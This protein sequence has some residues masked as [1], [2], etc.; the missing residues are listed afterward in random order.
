MNSRIFQSVNP[1]FDV[2]ES[3]I[4]ETPLGSFL[5]LADH[6][7]LYLLDFTDNP[8]LGQKKQKAITSTSSSVLVQSLSSSCS[9]SRFSLSPLQSI[10]LELQNYFA[11]ALETFTT[12]F[13][14]TGTPFQ[15]ETWKALLQIPFAK[16]WT[17]QEQA[18]ILGRPH[19]YRAVAN[20]NGANALVIL[21]PCHRVIQKKGN[22]GGYNGGPHRKQWLIHHEKNATN[23]TLF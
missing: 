11:G 19:A 1:C 9:G 21:V 23:L 10:E 22:V 17:Y 3:R 15:Q 18:K 20:A 6:K 13:Y 14:L 16:T 2:Q 5:A 12:P 4:I 7:A 8:D